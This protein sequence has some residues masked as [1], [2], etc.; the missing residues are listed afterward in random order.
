MFHVRKDSFLAWMVCFGAFITHIATIGIDNSFGIVIGSLIV[1]LDSS[2]T[3]ISWIQSVHSSFMFLFASLSSIMLKYQGFRSL[4]LIGT[5]LCCASYLACVWLENYVGLLIAYGVLGGAGSGML[6]TPANIACVHYFDKRKAI[7][8]GIAMSGGGFGTMGVSLLCNYMNINYGYKGYFVGI[9]LISSFTLL[10][11]VFVSPLKAEKR[12]DDT[13]EDNKQSQLQNIEDNHNT[14]MVVSVSWKRIETEMFSKNKPLEADSEMKQSAKRWTSPTSTQSKC[15]D[16]ETAVN[17]KDNII[18]E[19]ISPTEDHNRLDRDTCVQ[20]NERRRSSVALDAQM[21]AMA[22]NE[23]E[24]DPTNNQEVGMKNILTLMKD[25][26]MV[27][28]IMVH[29]MFELAYYVPMIFLPEMM[30]QDKGIPKEWAG[31]IISVLGLCH[32]AGKLLTGLLLQYSKT[33]PIIFSAVSMVL[34]GSGCLGLTFCLTYKHFVIVTALYGLFLS[35][36]DV[37]LPLILID[38]FGKDKLKDAYGLVMVG[39][40]F[41]P[42]WGPPIGG[43]FKDWTGKYSVAFYA[44]GTFQFIGAFFNVLVCIF[45]FKRKL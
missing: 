20:S 3:N 22:K 16:V 30:I 38:M 34:L 11:G 42:M 29:V 45:H 21:N 6:F 39:K 10:F 23:K 27:C 17:G 13:A 26:R 2:T 24:S 8:T 12:I 32:M 33:S 7:S 41:S 14:K 37:L 18:Q 19:G 31:T 4:V 43:A 1:S 40:M 9:C 5:I 35:S 15:N 25:M 28:Y 44:S 36:M